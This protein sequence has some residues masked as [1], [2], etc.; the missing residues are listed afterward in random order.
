[1]AIKFN[2]LYFLDS[3]RVSFNIPDFFVRYHC[4]I[5]PNNT[6]L[7][8]AESEQVCTKSVKVEV[9]IL[10]ALKVNSIPHK[11]IK[12][13]AIKLKTVMSFSNMGN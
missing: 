3:T 8:A 12:L 4:T 7:C 9:P 1:M 10:G 6:Q 5:T 13:C 11:E 2:Q